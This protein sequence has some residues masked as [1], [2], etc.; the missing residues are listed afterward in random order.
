MVIIYSLKL[1]EYEIWPG[2]VSLFLFRGRDWTMTSL[3]NRS[4]TQADVNKYI[5]W[6]LFGLLRSS[7]NHLLMRSLPWHDAAH[8]N[9]SIWSDLYNIAVFTRSFRKNSFEKIM[10]YCI[11]GKYYSLENSSFYIE[12]QESW[13]L[14]KINKYVHESLEMYFRTWWRAKRK[15]NLQNNRKCSKNTDKHKIKLITKTKASKAYFLKE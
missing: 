1:L 5:I 6:L 4:L 7:I 12:K 2:V 14:Q 15:R 13:H 8:D 10:L 11:T 3:H 9:R